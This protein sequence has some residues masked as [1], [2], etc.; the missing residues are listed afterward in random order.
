MIEEQ[1][2]SYINERN[3]LDACETHGTFLLNLQQFN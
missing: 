2:R 1:W 3:T